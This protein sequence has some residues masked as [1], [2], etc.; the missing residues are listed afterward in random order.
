MIG[1]GFVVANIH[2]YMCGAIFAGQKSSEDLAK[3]RL[4]TG[5]NLFDRETTLFGHTGDTQAMFFFGL[6]NL[7]AQ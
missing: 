1:H 5:L 4:V 2:E 6:S 7:R 3:E